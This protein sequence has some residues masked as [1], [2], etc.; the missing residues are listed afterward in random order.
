MEDREKGRVSL[1]HYNEINQLMREEIQ[2]IEEGNPVP[3][4]G[5]AQEKELLLYQEGGCQLFYAYDKRG[6]LIRESQLQGKWLPESVLQNRQEETLLH[7]YAY[8]A[9]NRLERAWNHKG[10]EATYTYNGMGQR[11]GKNWGT[12]PE[13]YILDLTRPYH[14][15]L[16]IQRGEEEESYYWDFTPIATERKNSPPRYYLADELGSP[17]RVL[18]STGKGECYGY[19]EFGRDLSLSEEATSRNRFTLSYTKQGDSQPFGYTGYRYDGISGS[20]FAQAREYQPEAGR[21]MAEDVIRGRMAVP[22]TLNRYGYC[23]SNPVRFVDLDGKTETDYTVYYLNN[24]D[25]AF[26]TGHTALLVETPNGSS[27]FFSYTSEE[28][29]L[30]KKAM[31]DDVKGYMENTRL[32]EQETEIFLQNGDIGVMS[33]EGKMLYTN[34]DRAL[35]KEITQAEAELIIAMGNNYVNLYNRL[36][37]KNTTEDE[38]NS[39]IMENPQLLYNLYSNNCDTVARA[40]LAT[41]EP[42]L[43]FSDALTPNKSYEYFLIT[44]RFGGSWE[45]VIVGRNNLDE[46]LLSGASDKAYMHWIGQHI[47]DLAHYVWGGKCETE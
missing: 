8:D 28:G 23:L 18:Y 19:D 35:K 9:G 3:Q 27:H 1:Y 6:N 16:G 39:L 30:L 10:E 38:Y 29:Q 7:G 32:S 31:G 15:L 2:P 24:M 12:K 40:M 20:Y 36:Y 41:V 42:T 14:N 34:Y 33:Y 4:R 21:F 45:E 46:L 11:V 22:K 13:E 47:I 37:D 17:L 5:Q 43:Y 26:K 25:G 44:T